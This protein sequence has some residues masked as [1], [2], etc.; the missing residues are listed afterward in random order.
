LGQE[1]LYGYVNQPTH[2]RTGEFMFK[3][4]TISACALLA[5]GGG[6]F[7]AAA[8]PAVAQTPTPA[9]PAASAPAPAPAPAPR[10]E[11]ATQQIVVSGSRIKRDNYSSVSPL[12]IIRNEDSAVAGFSSTAEV[13][14]GTAVT[15]GQGQVNNAFGGFVT[16]GGP[17]ANTVGLRGF[18]PTRSL[19]LLNGRRLAPSGTRGAVGAADLNTLPGAI[20]DRIEVLKDGA[21][22]IYGSDAVAGVINIITKKNLQG[23]TFESRLGVP[24]DGGGDE[25]SLG[26]TYGFVTDQ[27][28]L[29]G[30]FEYSERTA[31]T[32]GQRDWT[33]C[34]TDYRRTSVDGVVGQWGSR[35]FVDP[36]TGQPKC[37]PISGTGSN[38]VTINTLGTATRAGVGAPGSVGTSFNRWRPNSAITTGFAGFEGVGGGTNNLNVRDTFDPRTLNRSLI[39]PTENYNMYLQGGIDLPALG[40]AELYTEFM[41]NRRNSSQ[42]GYR[43][44]SLDYAVANSNGTP[45]P[46]VP[47]NLAV[48]VFSAPTNISNGQ[49]VR[50]RAFIGFGNDTSSQSVDFTRAVVGLRGDLF[51]TG[52]DYDIVAT[53]SDSKGKYTFQSFLT[54]RLAQSLNVV[55][56]G[57]GFACVDPSGGCVAAPALTPAVIGGQLPTAWVNYV[58][59]PVT[60]VSKYKEDVVSASVTGKIF[61]L[62]YGKVKAALGAEYRNF[63]IDDTPALDSQNG[64][65]FNLTTSAPTRGS[66]SA[67]DVFAEIDIPL[68]AKLPF[69]HDLS[70]SAS[71]RWS[72]YKSY[73]SGSTY[74]VGATWSPVD[75]LTLRGTTSTSYRAPALYEQFLGATSG[76]LSQQNDPC[77]NWGAPSN[78]GTVRAANCQAEGLPTDF[79]ATSGIAVINGGGA[80]AGLKAETSENKT[81]GIILQPKLAT[82]WGDLSLSADYFDIQVDNGVARAGALNILARCYDDPQFRAGGGF[83][84][85]VDPR[86]PASQQLTVNDGFINLATDKVSGVD[87]TGRYTTDI[88]IGKLRVNLNITRFNSQANQ[89]FSD[90]P[91]DD[92]N[93][94]INNPKYSGTLDFNYTVKDWRFYYGVDW[95]GKMSSYEY[96]RG[97]DPSN[98]AYET[99]N[100][101]TSTFKLSVPNYYLQTVSV[102]YKVN[103][104]EVTA[105]VRNIADVKPP[106]ISAQS[107]YNRVGNAPLYSGY[108]YVGRTGFLNFSASF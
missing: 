63:K 19:V 29:S 108:D 70:V 41:F 28:R 67:K 52:W 27:S 77:N 8:T 20:V 87:F 72:D 86:N 15:G 80:T 102:R 71:S 93:G 91:V 74:K 62:P 95:V 57:S 14:Q 5:L 23:F 101:A 69:A 84:R 68:L 88:S 48:G 34:N 51:K 3:R 33:Q 81:F 18:T 78:A 97:T 32:L 83:C 73:G 76:F 30:S 12:Q 26:L 35:D 36:R 9:V 49:N 104:W 50:A 24:L 105:G 53:H 107:I 54:N 10:A 94:T 65:L 66:D 89:L 59:Q 55:A 21:S 61:D 96:L 7:L 37:Y 13:L 46:L 100:P 106:T 75:W 64:N 44:L 1:L 103:K 79:T 38:G 90:D 22:S 58:W 6:A 82:G 45:N 31:L 25:S 2:A 39:S 47:A 60:G 92:F 98:P 16:D 11:A 56:S 85:L 4:T 40:G 42:T 17:G 43:Q 99:Y